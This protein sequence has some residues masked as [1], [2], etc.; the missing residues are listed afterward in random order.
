MGNYSISP[1]FRRHLLCTMNDNIITCNNNISW[2]PATPMPPSPKSGV[3]TP[4]PSSIDAYAYAQVYSASMNSSINID[5]SGL[6]NLL[7]QTALWWSFLA[8]TLEACATRCWFGRPLCEIW[9]L[10]RWSPLPLVFDVICTLVDMTAACDCITGE[11]LIHHWF[12]C[13]SSKSDRKSHLS[14]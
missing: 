13:K 14:A 5:P 12:I 7:S 11:S 3:A 4:N 1:N 8:S 6:C 10:T 9:E 2:P